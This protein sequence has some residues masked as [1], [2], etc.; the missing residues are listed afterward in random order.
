MKNSSLFLLMTGL[1]SA[2]FF[3]A[4]FVLNRT[5]S[6]E[7]GH[8]FWSAGLR[9]A[10]TLSFLSVGIILFK[11][12]GYFKQIL[13]EFRTHFR[14]WVVAGT[15]GFGFFYGL[16]C[17]AADFAPGWIV[18]TTWQFTIIASLFVL[19]LFGRRLSPLIWL[20]TCI[21]VAGITLVNI[22]HFETGDVGALLLGILPVLGAA[23]SYPLGNQL[24]WENKH[25]RIA[26]NDPG[27]LLLNNAFVKV[28]LLTLGSFP[29]WIVLFLTLDV[30][31]P[32]TEQALNVA[33]IALLSGIIATSLFLYARNHADTPAKLMVV[34]ATQS[35]EV[36]F[37][38]AGEV[39]FLGAALPGL[40]GVSGI[41]VTLLGLILLTKFNK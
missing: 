21:V 12:I 37:A 2:L 36:F 20:F 1:L 4:T 28:F 39:L 14:F 24:V 25:K 9:F 16:I 22:S 19:A 35:G 13:V 33:M 18:A 10:F 5:I 38:L 31:T 29:L 27:V 15:V 26:L 11:G 32:S 40:L 41:L 3:S 8:W 34:D 23:F 17:F 30:S 7:G 6:L